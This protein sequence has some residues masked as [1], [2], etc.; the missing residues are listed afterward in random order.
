MAENVRSM[1]KK[2]IHRLS[3]SRHPISAQFTLEMCAAAENCR[4]DTNTNIFG[5]RGFKV[6]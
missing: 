1:L 3:R 5:G 6:I 4:K 2:S